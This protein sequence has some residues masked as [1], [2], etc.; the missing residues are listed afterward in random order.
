M[1][2][3]S[4]ERRVA[5]YYACSFAA[6]GSIAPFLVLWLDAR[7]VSPGMIGIIVAAPSL[8]MILTTVAIGRLLDMLGDRRR[9]LV[10]LNVSVLGLHVLMLVADTTASILVLWTLAGLLMHALMPAT[11]ALALGVARRQGTDWARLR[12]FGSVGFVIAIMLAG[13]LYEHLGIRAFLAVLIG[14]SVLRLVTARGLPVVPNEAEIPLD[15]LQQPTSGAGQAAAAPSSVA[16]S[17]AATSLYRPEILL[18]LGGAALI[19]ASHAFFY[20][21]GLLV[22]TQAGIGET[23]GSVLWSV[24]VI[25]EIALMWAFASIG[26]R[27]S[28]RACLMVAGAAG[29]VR[30]AVTAT[31]TALPL[32]IAAQCLHALTFGLMYVATATFISRHVAEVDAARGHSLGA[33][34]G[35]GAMAVATALSG[36]LFESVGTAGYVAM[37]L[38]CLIGTGLV[39]ASYRTR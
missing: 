7:A 16:P 19:N 12:L 20:T 30:W 4:P 38:A 23:L 10:I 5:L 13:L 37:G 1:L 39:L 33:T 8:V 25:A 29:V 22:W 27:Y 3:R 14:G 2:T 17:P 31:T 35:A 9:G 34:F 6:I 18:T 24:G 15:A 26:S 28:A 21:F 32:L 11:D 36:V